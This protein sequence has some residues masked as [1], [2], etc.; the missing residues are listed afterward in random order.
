M[1]LE[2][3]DY[4]FRGAGAERSNATSAYIVRCSS[5]TTARGSDARSIPVTCGSCQLSE[6]TPQS[7]LLNLVFDSL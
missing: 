2:A 1:S 3:I 4:N 6:L 7:A 5:I